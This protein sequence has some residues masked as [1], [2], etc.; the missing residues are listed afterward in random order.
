M[1]PEYHQEQDARLIRNK[2]APRDRVVMTKLF[3]ATDLHGSESCFLKFLN[4]AKMYSAEVLVLGG[5]LTGKM[6]IPI[7]E[8]GSS[9]YCDFLQQHTILKSEA[10]VEKCEKTIE[11]SG[12]Y[13]YRTN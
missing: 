10:E 4:S 1:M 9:H 11:S 2:E 12:F 13:P 8:Q 6:I 7:I 3:F 5:D